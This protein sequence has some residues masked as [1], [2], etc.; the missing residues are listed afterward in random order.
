METKSIL[1][2]QSQYKA[3]DDHSNGIDLVIPH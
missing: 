2:S 3:A 1:I